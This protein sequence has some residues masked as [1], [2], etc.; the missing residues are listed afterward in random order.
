MLRNTYQI[1][2]TLFLQHCR[3]ISRIS[4]D[5]LDLKDLYSLEL[6]EPHIPTI[7]SDG[8]VLIG[9]SCISRNLDARHTETEMLF[10]D[11]EHLL[12]LMHVNI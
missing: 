11:F 9:H 7:H 6:V 3:R 12:L 10:S 8:V 5:D 1:L 4:L 2:E